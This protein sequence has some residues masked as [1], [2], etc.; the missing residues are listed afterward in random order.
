[1]GKKARFTAVL[2]GVGLEQPRNQLGEGGIQ[3]VAVVGAVGRQQAMMGEQITDRGLIATSIESRTRPH[4]ARWRQRRERA[5]EVSGICPAGPA[6]EPKNRRDQRLRTNADRL[7]VQCLRHAEIGDSV[8]AVK[9][10]AIKPAQPLRIDPK[11]L[12]D[13]LLRHA[14]PGHDL[15]ELDHRH[16]R[17]VSFT[18]GSCFMARCARRERSTDR[19]GPLAARSRSRR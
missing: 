3:P 2:L 10:G 7:A 18:S 9:L 12:S 5:V 4:A 8:P 6:L 14:I 13:R 1:M 16:A 17:S 19:R 15:A 11:T